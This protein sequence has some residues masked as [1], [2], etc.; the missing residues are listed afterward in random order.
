[1]KY[2]LIDHTADLGIRVFAK[3]AEELFENAA[4][5]LFDLI[6]DAS[7]L[8]GN[9][10]ARIQVKGADRADLMVNW[11]R[12]LLYLWNGKK[13]LVKTVKISALSETGLTADVSYDH[14]LAGRHDIRLEIKAVTYHQIQV[15]GGAS[16]WKATVIFD[17]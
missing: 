16:G 12:E 8:T 5:A 2:K 3:S 11:L 6:T 17:V 7:V 15:S 14:F 9:C 4:M 1:M 10:Q 13:R